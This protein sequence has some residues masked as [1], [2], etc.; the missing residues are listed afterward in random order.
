MIMLLW[1]FGE[2]GEEPLRSPLLLKSNS[3]VLTLLKTNAERL[4][5]LVGYINLP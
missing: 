5:G 1:A 4:P 2:R 3:H